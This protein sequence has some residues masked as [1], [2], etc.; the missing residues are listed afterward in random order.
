VDLR[1]VISQKGT[2]RGFDGLAIPAEAPHAEAAHAIVDDRMRPDV[3]ARN[4][5]FIRYATANAA[6]LEQ[7]EPQPRAD[8]GIYPAPEVRARLPP[9]LARTPEQ[10]CAEARRWTR[11][12]TGR[13]SGADGRRAHVDSVSA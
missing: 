8:A 12:R 3:A 10:R 7:V 1:Y 6:A 5:N 13:S 9:M 11:F 2:V 4:A